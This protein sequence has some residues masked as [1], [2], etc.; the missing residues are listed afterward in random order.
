M[1]AEEKTA[2]TL[3]SDTEIVVSRTFEAPRELVWKAWTDP[4]HL[5]RW[6]GPV[7]FSTTTRRI[8]VK[9]GG[10]WRFVMHGPDG[11]DYENL[12]TFSE[13][14][15]PER[16]VY[17][18]G[19]EAEV[20][21]VNFRVVVTFAEAGLGRTR[22]TMTSV[23]PSKKARDFVLEKYGAGEGAKQT[24]GRLAEHLATLGAEGSARPFLVT[25]VFDAPR[26]RVWKAW[27]SAE[28]LPRWFGPKGTAIVRSSLDLRVGGGFYYCMRAPDGSETWGKWVFR[29][30]VEGERLVFVLSFADAAGNT[31][32]VPFADDW[33]RQMLSTVT[34]AEHAGIR[35]GTVVAVR[36]EPIDAS[37]VERRT[38]DEG[39]PSMEA[40]W[41]GTFDVLE[42][43][44]R[45]AEA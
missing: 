24:L 42:A 12:I 25:R 16:L 45:A 39:H 21:P 19:G 6:W 41:N 40:G 30:I 31:I 1:T 32:R 26:D 38:F 2:L 4:E 7:G 13:V 18:H 17:K 23:F 36:S 20:E 8:A 34:F 9:P 29:E 14:V 28:H 22:L 10:Q 27:T 3:A 15:P 35:K 33:P 37:A 43:Y 44:L 11:R 5:P